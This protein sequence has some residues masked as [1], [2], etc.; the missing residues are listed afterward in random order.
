MASLNKVTL[1]GNLGN[2]PEAKKTKDGD[3]IANISLATSEKWKDKATGEAR[4]KTEWHRVSFFGNLADVVIKYLKKGSQIYV[5]GSMNTKKYVDKDGVEKYATSVR[6]SSIV[7][8]GGKS[9]ASK[10]AP[11]E[12]SSTSDEDIP[13]N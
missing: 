8:L 7:M 11:T 3:S 6:A 10:A 5:E 9:D 12:A 13:F 1:I 4:E 2:D